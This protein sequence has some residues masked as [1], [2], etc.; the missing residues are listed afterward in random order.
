MG[1]SKA[2]FRCSAGLQILG[3]TFKSLKELKS[4][5]YSRFRV[6]M[7]SGS[8]PSQGLLPVFSRMKGWLNSFRGT[9]FGNSLS[10]N[11][12]TPNT[13]PKPYMSFDP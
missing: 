6:K 4:R 7:G 13:C 11:L 10:L 9:L 2:P 12:R 1:S 5:V 8:Q 3:S